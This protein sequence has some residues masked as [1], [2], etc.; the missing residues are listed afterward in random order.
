MMNKKVKTRLNK[1]LGWVVFLILLL[2]CVT[3][4]AATQPPPTTISESDL[5]TLIVGTA[6]AAQI[7]TASAQP[8]ITR[9]ATWTRI[10]SETPTSTPT[11]IYLLPTATLVPSYTPIVP[12]GN[13]IVNGTLTTLTPDER[14]TKRPWTCLV[15]GSVPPRDSI[16]TSGK[17]FWVTWTV[18]NTGTETWSNNAIDF[19][20]ASGYR[21]E[22]RQI[23][24]LSLS[25][26]T[27]SSIN[28]KILLTAPN[29]PSTYNAI[30]ALKVGRQAFCHMK[31][32][33]TV[34]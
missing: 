23:Q 18:M 9:T 21:T 20:Y 1:S 16:Q 25:V 12:P 19:V 31:I 27:G 13:I 33:F 28:L 10:P 15:L 6:N 4:G 14:L 22:Q 8:T 32:V 26:K 3:P 7:Q 17:D 5:A 11:F 29:K 24:D 34:K 30:W 2:A